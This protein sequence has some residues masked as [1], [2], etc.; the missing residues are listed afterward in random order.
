VPCPGARP[1]GPGGM[2]RPGR[3]WVLHLRTWR[4]SPAPWV[5]GGPGVDR[6][7]LWWE[8]VRPEHRACHA[9]LV[10]GWRMATFQQ[11]GL[12]PPSPVGRGQGVEAP[13]APP[14]GPTVPY[15]PP[16]PCLPSGPSTA[17][18]RGSNLPVTISKEFG[19]AEWL[20][21]VPDRAGTRGGPGLT[22]TSPHEG[23]RAALHPHLFRGGWLPTCGKPRGGPSFWAGTGT[24]GRT[25]KSDGSDRVGR[26]GVK[27]N[28][29]G[30]EKCAGGR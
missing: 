10:L 11:L 7:W 5:T 25:N 12:H 29:N 20:E 16:P 1:S 17:G 6:V 23:N 27:N 28:A 9:N 30:E 2:R 18:L 26:N 22:S 15:F 24:G 19:G 8:G 3:G 14:H 4:G 21:H 13:R